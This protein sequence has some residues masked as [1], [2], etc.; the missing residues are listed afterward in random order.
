MGLALCSTCLLLVYAHAVFCLI[1]AGVWSRY[2]PLTCCW[3]SRCLIAAGARSRCNYL[4]VSGASCSSC[5]CYWCLFAYSVLCLTADGA[6]DAL[7]LHPYPCESM[8]THPEPSIFHL[9]YFW[10]NMMFGEISPVI[11]PKSGHTRSICLSMYC[12]CVPHAPFTPMHPH[13]KLIHT[14]SH[15][16]LSVYT[17]SFHVYIII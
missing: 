3:C 8:C 1:A 17:T 5:V 7:L 12:F 10:K 9:D 15:L 2:D 16:F 11:G 13:N 14:H 6:R 4:F